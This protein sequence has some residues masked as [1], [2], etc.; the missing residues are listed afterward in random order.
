[1]E[2]EQKRVRLPV[3]VDDDG[4]SIDEQRL[5]ESLNRRIDELAKE[6][7][8]KGKTSLRVT[9]SF[10]LGVVFLGL[11]AVLVMRGALLLASIMVLASMFNISGIVNWIEGK[12][13]KDKDEG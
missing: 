3:E 4:F 5:D 10:V 2:R 11:V 8:S 9:I 7:V 6:K 12:D 1:M 13:A